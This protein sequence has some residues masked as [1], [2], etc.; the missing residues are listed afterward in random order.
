MMRSAVAIAVAIASAPAAASA[1]TIAVNEVMYRPWNQSTYGRYEF[2]EVYNYGAEAVDLGG[3]MLTD[4]QDLV[5]ICHFQHPLDYEGV[6]EI[7]AG[8]VIG[9]GEYLTLWHTHIPGVTDQPGNIVYDSFLYFGNLV[10]ADGGDQVTIFTCDQAADPVI[11]D[12][13][14]YSLLTLSSLHNR[15]LERISPFAPTQ[16]AGNWGYTTAPTGGQPYG[17]AY[18]PGGT[19]GAEN[20]IADF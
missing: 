6:F 4:S 5:R 13:F 17:G 19:P 18:M 8:T 12:S 7:P 10:L 11:V 14:D 15:S 20:T 16:D 1:D 2:V 3:Y 9:P